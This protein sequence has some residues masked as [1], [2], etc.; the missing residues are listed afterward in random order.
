MIVVTSGTEPRHFGRV[1][2]GVLF[3]IAILLPVALLGQGYFGTVSGE[4]TDPSGA[5]LVGAEVVLADQAKGFAFHTTSDNSGRYLFGSIS[6]GGASV[7]AA[8]TRLSQ[9]GGKSTKEKA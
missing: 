1:F 5:I 9:E 4:L 3:V 8:M 7:S 2:G 6:S